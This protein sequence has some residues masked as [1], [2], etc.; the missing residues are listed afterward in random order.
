MIACRWHFRVCLL[1]CLLFKAW[2]LE[3]EVFTAETCKCFSL[4]WWLLSSKAKFNSIVH[5]GFLQSYWFCENWHQ[6][7]KWKKSINTKAKAMTSQLFT[8]PTRQQ[9]SQHFGSS[10]RPEAVLPLTQQK[11]RR[12]LEERQWSHKVTNDMGRSWECGVRG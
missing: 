12:L 10:K 2:F 1:T 7:R 5:M 6:S 4:F 9:V 11:S 3:K 8:H